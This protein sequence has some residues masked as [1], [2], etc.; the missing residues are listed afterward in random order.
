MNRTT[1]VVFGVVVLGALI[2]LLVSRRGPAQLE[3]ERPS[4]D[5]APVVEA[6]ATASAGAER[7]ERA[8]SAG[9]S[10]TPAP[11]QEA[12]PAP[13][14]GAARPAAQQESSGPLRASGPIEE[15]KARF[16]SDPR[17][18]RAHDYEQL[19]RRT[20][21]EKDIPEALLASA[22]CKKSVCR[23]SLRWAPDRHMGTMEGLTRLVSS[24]DEQ[25]AFDPAA[26]AKPSGETD[27]DVYFARKPEE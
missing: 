19:I 22:L 26:T 11:E 1:V 6:P 9:P 20:F 25:V 27:V 17:D 4:P 2:A 10:A 5:A 16:Q 13:P 8:L 15:M 3:T 7:P 23:V 21:R 12:A 24:F 14:E 18:P